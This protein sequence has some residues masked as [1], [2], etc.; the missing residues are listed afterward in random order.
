MIKQKLKGFTLIE[1]MISMTLTGVLIVFIFMGYN[2]I[3]KLFVGTAK[4]SEFI[5][6]LNLLKNAL[7]YTADHCQQIEKKGENILVFKNDP[8]SVFLELNE[9]NILLKFSSHT[10]TFHLQ[11]ANSQFSFLQFYNLEFSPLL[12][13]FKCDIPFQSQT[14]LL[15]FEKQYETDV[16]LRSRQ[17][18]LPGNEF[19]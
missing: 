14:Y 1:L 9:K 6:E 2:Q 11:P 18:K 10:D 19:N 17:K 7:F 13:S 4:Q 5:I 8:D 15:T 12:T 16:I 3:Q